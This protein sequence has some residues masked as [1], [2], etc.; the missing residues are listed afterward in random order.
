M[1]TT[2]GI[3]QTIDVYNNSGIYVNNVIRKV[4]DYTYDSGSGKGTFTLDS[5][6]STTSWRI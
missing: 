1:T 2:T 3:N 4:T 6:L 5:A